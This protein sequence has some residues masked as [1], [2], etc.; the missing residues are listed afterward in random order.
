MGA[1]TESTVGRDRAVWSF[2]RRTRHRVVA[3]IRENPLQEAVLAPV[4]EALAVAEGALIE[5]DP[6]LPVR[7]G[8]GPR[9]GS[10]VPTA[11]EGPLLEKIHALEHAVRVRE[12]HIAIVAHDLRS[13]MTPVL[14]LVRRLLEDLE[15][16]GA[17]TVAARAIWA[18]VDA[19]S[20]RLEQFVGKLHRLLDATRLQTEDLALE[21][22]DLDLPVLVRDVVAEVTAELHVRPTV[23][24]TG[25]T[26]LHGRWD[27]LRIEEIV[28]NLLANALRFGAAA[29]ITV[30]VRPGDER[31]L[32]VV[33]VRD[34]GIGIAPADQERIFDKHVRV[35]RAPG[36]FGLG[37]WI[38]RQLS[39]AMGGMVSVKSALGAGAEFTVVLPREPRRN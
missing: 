26:S 32:A 24:V 10:P 1:V 22:E 34:R 25:V 35:A 23:E 11:A 6:D 27:R 30:E 36:G 4:I 16:A 21:P 37:L 31:D 9:L 19:I 14:L 29:P 13:P 28:R 7:R 2:L 5:Q 12:E 17:E 39:R 3:A 8:R 38:V 15:E 20:H 33:I 18:K